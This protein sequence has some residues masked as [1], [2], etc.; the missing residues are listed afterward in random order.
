MSSQSKFILY[1]DDDAD[2][3]ELLKE[4]FLQLETSAKIYTVSSGKE[5][6]DFLQTTERNELPCLIV[7]DYN[8]PDLNGAEV[9]NRICRDT[10]YSKIPKVIWST[11]NSSYYKQLC[12][13][14]GAD[15]YFT[16]PQNFKDIKE[17]AGKMLQLCENS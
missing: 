6:L 17:M 3:Q 15:Y 12:K 1:A 2:D 13:E 8:M 16:K 5:T 14:K 7:L 11:S 4:A 10:R 9:L